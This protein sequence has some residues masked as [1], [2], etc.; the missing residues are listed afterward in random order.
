MSQKPPT[1]DPRALL[2]PA[3]G[4]SILRGAL[5]LTGWVFHMPG[6]TRAGPS[7]NPMV[8][9]AAVGFVLDGLALISLAGGR[10]R[11]AL[12]GAAWSLISGV[13]T[14]LEYGL[15]I[16]R[17]FDQM[18]AIDRITQSAHPGRLAPNTALCF[19]LCGLALWCASRPRPSRNTATIIGVLG[20]VVMAFGT[21]S[22]LGYLAGYPTY[23]WGQWTQMAANTSIGFVML[24]LGVVAVASLGAR[25]ASELLPRLPPLATVCA[26]L[27]VTLSFA[28]GFVRDVESEL[29]HVFS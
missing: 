14:L 4:A 13:L 28:Y 1:L 8:A 24:G 23:T 19:V 7:F 11:S 17:G 16:E 9:N 27:T 15:S 6:L 5:A 21:A 18:L 22:F 25:G 29:D 10:R 12:P 26:R 3:G 20:A 2:L